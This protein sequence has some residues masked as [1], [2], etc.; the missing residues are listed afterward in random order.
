MAAPIMQLSDAAATHVRDLIG[1]AEKPVLGLRVG[2]RTQGCSGLSYFVEY[3]EE[4]NPLE[5]IVEDKGVKIFVDAMALMYFI[6]VEMDYQEDKLQS[7][8]IFNNPNEKARCGCGES[9]SI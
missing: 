6:G 5:E 7:G 2:V 9:F 3:A 4:Q 8:F 1:R